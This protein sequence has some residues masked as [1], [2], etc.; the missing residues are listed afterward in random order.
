MYAEDAIVSKLLSLRFHSF[1][2]QDRHGLEKNVANNHV[3]SVVS[4]AA[5][6]YLH[7]MLD[8]GEADP[9]HL[10]EI[11]DW[12]VARG[13]S[14]DREVLEEYTNVIADL[15][16]GVLDQGGAVHSVAVS[17]PRF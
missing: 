15:R 2:E 3:R 16:A 6:L 8:K 13:R 10:G 7:G 17:S 11:V 9:D 1:D 12:L 4:E 14:I 5:R